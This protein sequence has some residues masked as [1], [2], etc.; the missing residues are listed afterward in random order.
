MS[1]TPT[2]DHWFDFLCP[3]CYLAQ[4]R[5][6]VLR[7]HG[8]VVLEHP[9]QI[10]PEIGPGGTA[11]GP[12]VGPTYDFLAS[13][14]EAA[15]L[16]LTWTDRIAYS[17]PA[18]GAYATLA[19]ADTAA[20]HTDAA[21][22]TGTADTTA[23]AHTDAAGHGVVAGTD[24]AADATVGA[25]A[26][27]A[28]DTGTADTTAGA[29]TGTA[30]TTAGAGTGTADT[31]V[32]DRFAASV[33]NAYFGEGK[34]LESRDLLLALTEAAGGDPEIVRA[35]WESGEADRAVGKSAILAYEN[36]VQGTPAWVAGGQS[37]SG[38]RPRAWFE[39]WAKS[40]A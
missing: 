39:N 33:F 11:V 5:N 38:L 7:E 15:G 4:D 40:L 18:L 2:V 32:A 37:V 20:A 17:L 1:V 36:G 24:A 14:A 31:T 29:D 9:L 34:D 10:H 21:A 26:T 8:V 30:D 3:F 35:A 13:E 23:A 19:A 16:P 22:D 6:R 12:R 25:D 28:A 27:A